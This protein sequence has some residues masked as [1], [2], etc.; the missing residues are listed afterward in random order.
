MTHR[1]CGTESRPH[2]RP[3]VVVRG[4]PR[5]RRS[6][7]GCEDSQAGRRSTRLLRNI[8][9]DTHPRLVAVPPWAGTLPPSEFPFLQHSEVL[10]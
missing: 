7:D 2:G 10:P 6:P 1:G 5:Q 9:A 8:S 4:I 3:P